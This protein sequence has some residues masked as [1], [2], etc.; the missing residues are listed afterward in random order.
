[1]GK[2]SFEILPVCQNNSS[3]ATFSHLSVQRYVTPSEFDQLAVQGRKMG[4]KNVASGPMVR[5]SY[6]A[7]LLAIC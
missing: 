1:L 4:F 2:G 6:R 7:E 5:S 3:L